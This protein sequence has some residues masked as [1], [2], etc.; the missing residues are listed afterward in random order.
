MQTYRIS[1][2]IKTQIFSRKVSYIAFGAVLRA[3][4]ARP[5]ARARLGGTRRTCQ[6]RSQTGGYNV[7]VLGSS[8]PEMHSNTKSYLDIGSLRDMVTSCRGRQGNNCLRCTT[9]NEQR[10][11][12][13]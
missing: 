4:H 9:T 7:K 12:V 6:R 8:T 1:L 10:E 3:N 11:L 2:A 13:H 5:V